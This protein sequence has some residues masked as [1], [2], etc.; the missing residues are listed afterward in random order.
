MARIAHALA[1]YRSLAVGPLG[2]RP[3]SPLRGLWPLGRLARGARSVSFGTGG[4]QAAPLWR[5]PAAARRIRLLASGLG[6]CC[7][8]RP[9]LPAPRQSSALSLVARARGFGLLGGRELPA[10]CLFRVR[11]LCPPG[12]FPVPQGPLAA[13]APPLFLIQRWLFLG[14]SSGSLQRPGRQLLCL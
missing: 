14:S 3:F 11:P 2:R 8:R 10:W 9:R 6:V 4:G 5:P 1:L 13:A 12:F 7:R